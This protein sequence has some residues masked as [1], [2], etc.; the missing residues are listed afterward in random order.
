M[1]CR[2]KPNKQKKNY[3]DCGQPGCAVMLSCSICGFVV[4]DI[5]TVGPLQGY[6]IQKP[7][8]HHITGNLAAYHPDN[9][10][11]PKSC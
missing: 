3:D 1:V 4:C 11:P 2:E 6:L 5:L 10:K 8:A 7:V 9:W